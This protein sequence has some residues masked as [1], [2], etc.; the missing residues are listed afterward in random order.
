MEF[1]ALVPLLILGHMLADY[2]QVKK[3]GGLHYWLHYLYAV[4]EPA[5][6]RL[7]DWF[8]ENP[9][10]KNTKAGR[11]ILWLIASNK[12]LP[13]GVCIPT[14][15]AIRIVKDAEKFGGDN[16]HIAVGPC[17]CQ[18]ALNRFSE[19]V[20]KDITIWYGAE[21]YSRA[22]KDLYRMISAEEAAEILRQ[23]NKAGLTHFVEFCMRNKKWMFVICNC[24]NE[25]C[26]PKRIYDL[27]GLTM[28]PGPYMVVHD[29][30]KCV[31]VAQC[32]A[33]IERCH[34]GANIE[35]EGGVELV[36]DKCLGCGLCVTTCKGNARKLARRPGYKGRLLPID[37]VIEAEV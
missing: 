1:I 30:E 22:Y 6:L 11:F 27:T 15:A 36:M 26:C 24:D 2:G 34:F 16:A 21:V 9:F 4:S 7:A 13:H 14:A 19:P 12:L 29:Q 5:M 31:G 20:E 37:Y 25:I 32:G 28:L 33:C 18:K 8:V 35:I 3:E 17:V 10:F 23:C